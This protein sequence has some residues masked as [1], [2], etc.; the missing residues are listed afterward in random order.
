MLI[1]AQHRRA[2]HLP[3]SRLALQ[4][5]AVT[6]LLWPRR[7]TLLVETDMHCPVLLRPH[8][9]PIPEQRL[10]HIKGTT[11]HAQVSERGTQNTFLVPYLIYIRKEKN[12]APHLLYM[13]VYVCVCVFRIT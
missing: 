9:L 10:H 6:R 7:V 4:Q 8:A 1:A 5:L 13:Y 11:Q 3:A 12:C 2:P